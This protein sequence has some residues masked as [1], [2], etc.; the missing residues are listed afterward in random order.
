[1]FD[2]GLREAGIG[3]VDGLLPRADLLGAES[4]P[5]FGLEYEP[6]RERGAWATARVPAEN[7]RGGRLVVTSKSAQVYVNTL[8]GLGGE[9]RVVVSGDGR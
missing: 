3:H 8:H 2:P 9:L 5:P 1:V 7:P 6:L 4:A